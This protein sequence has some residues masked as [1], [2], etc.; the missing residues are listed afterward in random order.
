MMSSERRR[1]LGCLGGE[2]HRLLSAGRENMSAPQLSSGAVIDAHGSF[3]LAG[4]LI[5]QRVT[6][7]LKAAFTCLICTKLPHH[8]S[9]FC[10][11]TVSIQTTRPNCQKK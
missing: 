3:K 4:P 7:V 5:S 8:L 10:L 9:G 2:A 1:P 6:F 11:G